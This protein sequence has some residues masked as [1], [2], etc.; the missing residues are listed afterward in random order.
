MINWQYAKNYGE[1]PSGQAEQVE[2]TVEIAE[3]LDKLNTTLKELL[4]QIIN[5]P[6]S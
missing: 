4:E 2:A 5:K 1:L 6:M 3:Q